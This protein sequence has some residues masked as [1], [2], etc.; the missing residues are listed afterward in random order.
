MILVSVYSLF[1]SYEFLFTKDKN[2]LSENILDTIYKY[3]GQYLSYIEINYK[4]IPENPFIGYLQI[5]IIIL[6]VINIFV[7]IPLIYLIFL[8][9]SNCKKK[10][11]EK[12]SIRKIDMK[13]QNINPDELLAT[14]SEND[15]SLD[16]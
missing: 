1:I 11:K 3:V 13:I 16:S 4:F 14:N 5:S 12:T 8:H 9:T 10:T 6:I 7:L 2:N 15:T